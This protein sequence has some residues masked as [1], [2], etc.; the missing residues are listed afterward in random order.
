MIVFKQEQV[1]PAIRRIRGAG[2]VC[3]HLVEGRRRAA[4]IDTGYGLGD[5]KGYIES[6]TDKPYDVLITHGHVDHAGG[7][8]QFEKVYMNHADIPLYQRHCQMETRRKSL[9][10]IL[11]GF[12]KA[13]VG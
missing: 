3:M 1:T 9:K 11:S 2:D 7:V 12:C 5:L 13:P 6:L 4:L 10:K 8:G